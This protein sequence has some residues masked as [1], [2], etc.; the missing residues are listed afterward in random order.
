MEDGR[1]IKYDVLAQRGTHNAPHGS[2]VIE[3]DLGLQ[4]GA[5]KPMLQE[6]HSERRT[7]VADGR[8]PISCNAPTASGANTGP[9]SE[10]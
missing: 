7:T 3:N 2:Q 9:D 10:H 5:I 8:C 4:L 1:Y 6:M